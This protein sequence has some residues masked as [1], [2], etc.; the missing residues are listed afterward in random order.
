MAGMVLSMSKANT[1]VLAL[2][3][4]GMA[5]PPRINPAVSA[6]P[7]RLPSAAVKYGIQPFQPISLRLK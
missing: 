6:P 2:R 3:A 1:A 5:M 4:V 7:A